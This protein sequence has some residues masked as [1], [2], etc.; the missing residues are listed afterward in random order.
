[1]LK[2]GILVAEQS[3]IWQ[4]K[5]SCDLQYSILALTGVDGQFWR[6][7]LINQLVMS[8]LFQIFAKS[9][10]EGDGCR[11]NHAEERPI[12]LSVSG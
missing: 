11:V 1:M 8:V 12:L 7:D 6:S 4:P 9:E 5:R 3:L 10:L 2:D